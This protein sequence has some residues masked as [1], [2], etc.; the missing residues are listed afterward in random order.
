MEAGANGDVTRQSRTAPAQPYTFSD[1]GNKIRKVKLGLFLSS[2]GAC[3]SVTLLGMTGSAICAI[4]AGLLSTQTYLLYSDG[5]IGGVYIGVQLATFNF[6]L[7]FITVPAAWLAMGLSIGRFP[8]R[9]ITARLP[10]IRWAGIWGMVLVGGTTGFFGGM[11]GGPLTAAGASLSG[12]IIGG[13]AGM[14]CGLLFLAIVKPAEQL[15][16]ADISV[17]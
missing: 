8:H 13:L 4:I 5:F 2:L 1:A 10:Y 9:G 16:A 15:H 3:L 12:L 7:F 6:I 14:L 17:F 11:I